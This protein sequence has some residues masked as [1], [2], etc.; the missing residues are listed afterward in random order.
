MPTLQRHYTENSKHIFPEK[1]LRGLTPHFYI[2]VSASDLYIPTIGLPF[3]LQE[4]M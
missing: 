3:L 1:E 2:H 4:D